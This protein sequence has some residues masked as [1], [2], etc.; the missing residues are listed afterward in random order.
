MNSTDTKLN[1]PT[2]QYCGNCSMPTE[3]CSFNDKKI[4]KKCL[5]WLSKTDP[6]KAD[7]LV[8]TTTA[9]IIKISKCGIRRLNGTYKQKS[10]QNPFTYINESNASLY[11][12]RTDINELSLTKIWIII[13]KSH[14]NS[15]FMIHHYINKTLSLYP[16]TKQ[17]KCIA[18]IRPLPFIK[19]IEYKPNKNKPK[20]KL[21]PD[22]E[23]AN[24]YL[25]QLWKE[26][27]KIPNLMQTMF[28]KE[29]NESGYTKDN[30]I[31][32]GTEKVHGANL[33]LITDGKYMLSAKRTS[34]LK[35][36][37]G[38]YKGWQFVVNSEKQR[39]IKCY[40][41]I[42][43]NIDKS[44]IAIIVYGELFGGTYSNT[45]EQKMEQKM[46]EN[47]NRK[48]V[49]IQKG[50]DYSPK[51]HFY[52]FDILIINNE[53]KNGYFLEWN[54]M[55]LLLKE[56]GFT[57]YAT[58]VIEGNLQE[59]VRTFDPNVFETTIPKRLQLMKPI[60]NYIAEG[61][62]LRT[63]MG[64]RICI[65]YKADK[66]GEI[67]K[68]MQSKLKRDI[69]L[70]TSLK[71]I[72]ENILNNVLNNDREIID[73]IYKCINNNRLN[74]VSSKIGPVNKKNYNKII[75]NFTGDVW[76]EI[77]SLKRDKIKLIKKIDQNAIK[78]FITECI[79]E[80]VTDFIDLT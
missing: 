37:D 47:I 65:K 26:Y 60:H 20:I 4:Y 61:I 25:T 70:P 41:Y 46:K 36:D 74:S 54:K 23:K 34:I 22:E 48:Y 13:E 16:P 2:I 39:I 44:V 62:V 12:I 8:T 49:H 24:K 77:C 69:S 80:F 42:R 64:K 28:I 10:K 50:V 45:L 27:P 3:Y 78:H 51:H 33:S 67:D 58:A 68:D 30:V 71:D 53:N 19:H 9:P 17:W 79:R 73:L 75:G 55:M 38:F 11:I 29:L 66:F 31:W 35:Y 32:V 18:G 57:L 15:N 7:Q 6:T 56:C 72:E 59:I 52:P 1:T 21:S 43:N 63:K 14:V 5:K 40:E 76:T